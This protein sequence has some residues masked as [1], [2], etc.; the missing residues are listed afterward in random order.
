MS[1]FASTGTVLLNVARW[2]FLI[3]I[4]IAPWAFGATRPEIADLLANA[5]LGIVLIAFIGGLFQQQYRLSSSKILIALVAFLLAT[6]WA[7]ALRPSGYFDP[8]LSRFISFKASTRFTVG[9]VDAEVSRT[10]MVRLTSLLLTLLF[11]ANT[12]HN[13]KWCHRILMTVAGTGVSIAMF[14]I[15]QKIFHAPLAFWEADRFSIT[16]FAMYRYHAN[17]GAYLNLTWPIC[18]A[19]AITAFQNPR[20]HLSRALWLPGALLIFSSVFVNISKSGHVIAVGLLCAFAL[21]YYKM[22]RPLRLGFSKSQLVLRSLLFVATCLLI[23]WLIGIDALS[24]RWHAWLDRGT[25]DDGRFWVWKVCSGMIADRPWFGFGPGTFAEVFPFY[26]AIY[27]DKSAGG[28]WMYA[29]CDYLQMILEWGIFGALGW[30]VLIFGGIIKIGSKTF[31]SRGKDRIWDAAIGFS[32]IGVVL[33]SVF[34]FPLEIASIQLYTVALL[35]C[36]WRNN[37]NFFTVQL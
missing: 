6:G 7:I 25:F 19:L 31:S 15:A 22:I 37:E 36:A 30:A 33:L 35:G 1:A 10:A 23:I 2:L 4:V 32:L 16:N 34:D 11:V 27:P 8:Y 13:P 29:H 12:A 20:A 17:A 21:T 9:T 18:G 3:V 24:L 28:S 26:C 14:G 5:L